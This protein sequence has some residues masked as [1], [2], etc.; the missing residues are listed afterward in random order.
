[1][2]GLARGGALVDD[3][4]RG[5]ALV[6]GLTRGGALV[7]GLTRG[8]AL[9][10][11]LARGGAL[12]DGLRVRVA[13]HGWTDLHVALLVP[14]VERIGRP[15]QALRGRRAERRGSASLTQTQVHAR[16]NGR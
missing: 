14:S 10:D 5:G 2:D 16:R 11:G 1:M 13:V 8:G 12:V 3:L 4:A 6:D 9:V 15:K 7:D